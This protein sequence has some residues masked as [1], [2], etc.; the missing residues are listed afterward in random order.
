MFYFLGDS[1]TWGQGLYFEKWIQEKSKFGNIESINKLFKPDTIRHE[2]FS[3]EDNQFRI[4]NSFPYLVSKHYNMNYFSPKFTNGGSNYDI[5][6]QLRMGGIADYGII[7]HIFIQLT[8]FWRPMDLRLKEY[9]TKEE[10]EG[11]YIDEYTDKGRDIN[12]FDRLI[13][14]QINAF[15]DLIENNKKCKFYVL[16]WHD[17][18]AKSFLSK[19]GEESFVKI[20]YKGTDYDSFDWVLKE[21]SLQSKHG[22]FDEHLSIEGHRVIADS[23]IRKLGDIGNI[24]SRNYNYLREKGYAKL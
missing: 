21:L 22:I 15:K 3:F 14:T 4:Q 7:S 23:I 9:F 10:Q 1:F 16:S 13:G 8:D 18:M 12:I 11:I 6:H 2:C 5:I 19:V 17:D 24:N 20:N